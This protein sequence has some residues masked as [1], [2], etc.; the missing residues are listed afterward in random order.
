MTLPALATV[1]DLEIRLGQTLDA[2]QRPQA[3]WLLRYAS[4]LIRAYTGRD[5]LD[6]DGNLINPLPDGVP[7]VCV[8]I[9]F[10]AVTNPT[11]ATQ[12]S[13]GPYALSLG[14]EAAQRMFL[15]AQDKII[16]GP[17]SR[18]PKLWTQ[19]TTRGDIE[20]ETVYVPVS[21]DGEPLPLLADPPH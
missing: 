6:D 15:S 18:R 8:E 16:L 3:E 14:P 10:R 12:Q 20:T 1:D 7:E 2:D 17:K 13:A 21:N 11:G 9:V 5:Y 19:P 4:A